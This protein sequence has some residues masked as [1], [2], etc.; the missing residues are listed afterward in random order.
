[1]FE[2][3][4]ELVPMCGNT[5]GQDIFICIDEVLQKYNLPLSK[6]TSVATDGAPSMTG[7]TTVLW[8]YC[9]KNKVRFM[10]HPRFII[11]IALYIKKYYAR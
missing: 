1:M 3:M 9:E 5:T 6:L 8:H 7:K 4:L 10:K 11:H 2:E